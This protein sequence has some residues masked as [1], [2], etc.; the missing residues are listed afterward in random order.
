MDEFNF[1]I[2]CYQ[3]ID[4]QMNMLDLIRAY[5]S[6]MDERN[7]MMTELNDWIVDVEEKVSTY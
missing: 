1:V 6:V 2:V 5:A 7:F 4:Q 3:K